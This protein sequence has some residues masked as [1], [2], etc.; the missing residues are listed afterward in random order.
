MGHWK[1]GVMIEESFRTR[2]VAGSMQREGAPDFTIGRPRIADVYV[3]LTSTIF[4]IRTADPD[5]KR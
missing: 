3:Y 5:F 4:F 2:K 1:N